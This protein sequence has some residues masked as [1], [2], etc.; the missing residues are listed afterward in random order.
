MPHTLCRAEQVCKVLGDSGLLGGSGPAQLSLFRPPPCVSAG[1][2][3]ASAP[4]AAPGA[5]R[6][7]GCVAARAFA[8]A[9][10]PWS[11]LVENI[12]ARSPTL[13]CS[14]PRGGESSA[15]ASAP[16]AASRRA[17]ISTA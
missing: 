2:A 1:A 9:R 13:A 12:K 8:Y 10:E 16:P 17:A 3:S 11:R 4:A 15:F 6:I 14:L 5:V 7:R